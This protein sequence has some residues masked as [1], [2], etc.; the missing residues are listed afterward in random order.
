MSSDLVAMRKML[1]AYGLIGQ[2]LSG[3]GSTANSGNPR[4]NKMPL[5]DELF[6]ANL[7]RL[8]EAHRPPM[9]GTVLAK[10]AGVGQRSI[11]RILT[12]KQIPTIDM[13]A[14]IAHVFDL[15]AWQ[16]LVPDLDPRVPPQLE[17]NAVELELFR[18][19]HVLMKDLALHREPSGSKRDKDKS[20][21]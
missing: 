6:R 15:E 1:A 2:A 17:P 21:K 8:M 7:R 16:M 4:K 18:K 12:S 5:V 3:S 20:K 9:S 19:W 11:G 14:K 10:S 13:V